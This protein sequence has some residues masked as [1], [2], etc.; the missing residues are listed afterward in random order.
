MAAPSPSSS[1]P[2]WT[3]SLPEA[4]RLPPEPLARPAPIRRGRVSAG[5]GI[6]V[7]GHLPASG[8]WLVSCYTFIYHATPDSLFMVDCLV[9]LFQLALFAGCVLA[10][11]WLV[12]RG[13]RGVGLGP[14]IGWAVGAIALVVGTILISYSVPADTAA[15]GTNTVYSHS[16]VVPSTP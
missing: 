4:P 1:D 11:G 12:L 7:V 5:I 2:Q 10:G 15:A 9:I 6:A 13:D 8:L 3:G 16:L 14:L